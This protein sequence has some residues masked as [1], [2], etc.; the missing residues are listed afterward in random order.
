MNSFFSTF[1]YTV[2]YVLNISPIPPASFIFPLS[3]PFPKRVSP[4]D[5]KRTTVSGG[6]ADTGSPDL[7]SVIKL[8]EGHDWKSS[9]H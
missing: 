9:F 8:L 5:V 6:P 3:L 4:I 1:N 7:L 2:W